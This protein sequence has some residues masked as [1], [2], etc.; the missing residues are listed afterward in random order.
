MKH[1]MKTMAALL[2]VLQTLLVGGC[3]V[4]TASTAATAA[5]LKQKEL[6]QG[7]QTM[8]QVQQRL[9]QVNQQAAQR[10]DQTADAG[11]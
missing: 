5:A 10:S 9:D 11:R 6:Q 8:Q 3:G 1:G 4:D 7:Q 2:L